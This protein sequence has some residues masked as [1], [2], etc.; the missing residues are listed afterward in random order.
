M[1]VVVVGGGASGLLASYQ[2]AKNGAEVFLLEKNEKFGKKLFLTGKGRCNITNTADK[3][4]FMRNIVRNAKFMI[5]SLDKFSSK[6]MC[7]L[8]K[9]YGL[10][11]KVERGG[12]IFPVSDKS[13]DVIKAL[14]AMCVKQNVHMRL[15]TKVKK[16]L[17][18]GN[19]AEGVLLDSGEKITADKVVV[20]TGGI[21]YSSTGSTGD[22]FAWAK[23]LGLETTPLVAGL[24]AMETVENFAKIEGLT[25]KNVVFSIKNEKKTL[26]ASEIGEMIFTDKGV[27]GPI[28][29]TAS[30]YVN[31]ENFPLQAGI[32]FKPALL[33]EQLKI[34]LDKDIANLKAKQ[35]K[36]LLELYLPKNIV[37][38]VLSVLQWSA[39][40]KVAQL[41]KQQRIRFVHVLKHF[42]L[43]IKCLAP[44]DRAIIT[45]GGVSV[46]E[47]NPQTMECKKIK[48]LHFIGEVLDVDA[49]TG[50]FN[51]QIAFSTAIV[52]ANSIR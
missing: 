50:G 32:D 15:R 28:V 10:D 22:G 41:S 43:T 6:Q 52:C 31:R 47:I 25:L 45:S 2:F 21:S 5:S 51:L 1:R 33:E 39:Q 23:E 17:C 14:V 13:S 20:A 38:F 12:R 11:V 29:L 36:A 30:S 3:E 27:S 48:N 44:I 7:L 8:L 49:L 35:C 24:N 40:D 9:E 46:K 37:P 18:T 16:I 4:T 34:R 19:S 26:F 42:P